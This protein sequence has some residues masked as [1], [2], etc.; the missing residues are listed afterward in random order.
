MIPSYISNHVCYCM[1]CISF[2]SRRRAESKQLVQ[3]FLLASLTC[4][5]STDLSCNFITDKS[6][7]SQT[8]PRDTAHHSKRVANKGGRSV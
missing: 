4:L 1:F 6:Q 5:Y 8:K 3:P 7:L 2:A